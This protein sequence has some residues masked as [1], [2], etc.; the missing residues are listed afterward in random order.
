MCI[1]K[2]MSPKCFEGVYAKVPLERGEVDEEQEVRFERCVKE[3]LRIQIIE[4]RRN[5]ANKS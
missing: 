3:E 2:Y 4:E 5:R 1:T